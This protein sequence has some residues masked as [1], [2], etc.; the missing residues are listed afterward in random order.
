MTI[1]SS[2]LDDARKYSK[3]DLDGNDAAVAVDFNGVYTSE[4]SVA[5]ARCV[6]TLY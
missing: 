5:R 6:K 2:R 3:I 1:E 4:A